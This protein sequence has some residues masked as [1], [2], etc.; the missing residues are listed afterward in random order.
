MS[1][2]ALP[3]EATAEK[4]RGIMIEAR[5]WIGVFRNIKQMDA[6]QVRGSDRLPL[7]ALIAATNYAV[8]YV[9]E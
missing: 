9:D 1:D 5:L 4:I 3:D 2:E 6:E 8:R 7:D